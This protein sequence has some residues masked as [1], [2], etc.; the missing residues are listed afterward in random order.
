MSEK[1]GPEPPQPPAVGRGFRAVPS[2][3]AGVL[4]FLTVV[5]LAAFGTFGESRRTVEQSSP[6]L[7]VHVEYPERYR[8]KQTN[9]LVA[10]ITN[11]SST[12]F[13]TLRLS[14]DTVYMRGFSN[15][16]ALPAASAPWE[17]ELPDVQPGE[18]R[19]V[20][21]EMQA[22]RYWRHSGALTVAGTGPG[23][24]VRV[25]IATFTWP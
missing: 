5:L 20:E 16:S 2:Q 17:I 23:D 6:R 9:R 13:D 18:T 25:E 15:V 7:A 3:I 1:D 8:Y 12:P 10:L 11:R 4:L 24:S 21:I 22:E 14:L 19:R